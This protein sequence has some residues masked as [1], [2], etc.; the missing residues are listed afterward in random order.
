MYRFKN[1]LA[2]AVVS[3]VAI[4]ASAP[5]S[6]ATYITSIKIT[7]QSYLQVA[8]VQAFSGTTN[9]AA[10]ANGGTASATSVY[11]A[12]SAA[13]NAIDGSTNGNYPAI[14][15]GASGSG[16]DVLTIS[17]ARA[18]VSTIN[19]FGRTDCCSNRDIYSYQLFDGTTL[20]G[21]GTADASGSTHE[22]SVAVAAVPEPATWTLMLTGFGMIGA[23][24]RSRKRQSVGVT[25]A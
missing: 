22:A 25:Y 11:S 3:L 16:S 9:V 17:F 7:A 2:T 5:A 20:V 23:G 21:S 13:G 4:A 6:A 12:E 24:V 1:R 18:L 8:E 10:S 19:L 14:Y 15:H